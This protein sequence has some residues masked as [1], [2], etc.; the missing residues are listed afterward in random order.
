MQGKDL[1]KRFERTN[2]D[3]DNVFYQALE[4]VVNS[5]APLIETDQRYKANAI[6]DR[7]VVP[8]G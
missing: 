1:V 4:E 8:D 2:C 6:L 3:E 5:I 7:L